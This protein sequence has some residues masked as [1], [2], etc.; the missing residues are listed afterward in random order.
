M[1]QFG[2][3]EDTPGFLG[4]TF[5]IY[6]DARTIDRILPFDVLPRILSAKEWRHIESGIMQRITAINLLLD[7][8][9]HNQH[10]LRDGLVP[11]DLILGNRNYR[12][13]MR[14]IDLPYKTYVN[15]CG[16]SATSAALSSCS[17]TM[18]EPLPALAMSS[19][20][21]T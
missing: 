16:R 2:V 7:D 21:G 20:T 18:R 6:S 1:P 8:I 12:P 4:I 15:I 9:Y 5:T 11:A 14:G 17:K 3:A 10:V 19:R 13:L